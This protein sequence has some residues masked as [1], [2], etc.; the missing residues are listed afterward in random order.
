M[1]VFWGTKKI[2]KGDFMFKILFTTLALGAALFAAEPQTQMQQP[3]ANIDMKSLDKKEVK[4]FATAVVKIDRLR[5]G[6]AKEMQASEE[7]PSKKEIEK[8]NTNFQAK[9]TG[10]IKDE[11]L[12]LKT[13]G[14]YVQLFQTNP[15]FQ[16]MVK[17]YLPKK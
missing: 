12:D 5:Q 1:L 6:L 10:I 14:Q 3:Q 9:A 15:E 13:Y 16:N 7:K 4:S 8:I 17:G 2:K 11:G